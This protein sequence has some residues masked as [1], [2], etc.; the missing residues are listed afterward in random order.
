MRISSKIKPVFLHS[1][2]TKK[3]KINTCYGQIR[4]KYSVGNL[5]INESTIRKYIKL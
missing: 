5:S 1:R 3:I 2:S 4:L